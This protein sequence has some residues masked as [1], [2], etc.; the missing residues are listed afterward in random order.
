MSKHFKWFLAAWAIAL[1][2]VIAV[3]YFGP[4][5][6]P[7]VACSWVENGQIQEAWGQDCDQAPNSAIVI[8]LDPN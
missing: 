3:R 7:Q 8:E 2:L 5:L 1:P 4:R 6:Q